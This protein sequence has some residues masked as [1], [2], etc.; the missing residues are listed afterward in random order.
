MSRTPTNHDCV[1]R[2][3]ALAREFHH[4]QQEHGREG[5]QGTT[6]RGLEAKMQRLVVRFEALLDHW[7]TDGSLR[8]A[9]MR[10][11]YQ[12]DPAPDE[13][14][15]PAPLLFKGATEAGG[16]IEIR[17]A[18]DGFHDVLL[19]GA[20]IRHEEVP[21]HLDS[22]LIGPVQIG[23]RTC[24]EVFAAPAEAVD[25][26]ATFLST[27][28]AEPPRAWAR[29]LLE[30]GL[31]GPDFEL[32]PRGQRRLTRL[33]PTPAARIGILTADTARARVYVLET[34][35]GDRAPT[36]APLVQV[37]EL[38][39]PERRARDRDVY[40]DTRPGLYRAS[41]SEPVHTFGDH[42]EDHRRSDAKHFAEAILAEATAIWKAF[43]ATRVVVAASPVMLGILRPLLARDRK[44]DR[45][46]VDELARDLTHLTPPHLHDMLATAGLVPE[47]G[48][49]PPLRPP[50]P[51]TPIGA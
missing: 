38:S 12:G 28:E 45:Y 42:R 40:T 30:D 46:T 51:G 47:R 11:L 41:G 5:V 13:P 43:H 21:W 35:H 27:P 22:D 14:R 4:V 24:V 23:E 44:P 48:R 33:S 7:V 34:T 19:D 3:V 29:A 37:A 25:A 10:H 16:I 1:S 9:W 20:V 8:D 36:R 2:L 31:I 49:Q 6:R 50:L 15:F 39:S 26:L 17:R 18:A 32:T